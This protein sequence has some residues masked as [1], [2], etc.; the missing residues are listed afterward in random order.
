M[1]LT[2]RRNLANKKLGLKMLWIV[3]GSLVFAF[4]LV[5]LYDVLCAMTGLN[6]K[7][8]TSASATSSNKVD[9]TRW[10][11]VQFTSSVMPGLGWNFYPKQSSIKVR[12]GQV[13]TVLFEAK[14][15]TSQVVA[16]QAIPSVTPGQ[17]A[18]HLQKIE[19]FC[20]QRQELK[21]GETKVMPLRFFVSRDLPE[22]V[23]EMT[24]S[25]SFFSA[26]EKE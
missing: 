3:A 2:E 24:L 19:C 15:I 21:P 17:A 13:E 18:A 26:K 10:V 23:K 16:G 20:F 7:T 22:D 5:P 9:T 14:N 4:A 25:Y 12:P 8:V 6:G 1:S 11:T